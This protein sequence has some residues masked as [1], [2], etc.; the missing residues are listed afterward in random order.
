MSIRLLTASA[1]ALGLVAFAP[2]AMAQ[3]AET[4]QQAIVV[5]DAAMRSNIAMDYVTQLTTRFGARP[6]GSRSEQQAA[7]W[8][9]DYLRANGF[10]NVRIEEFP[11]VGWERGESS[12]AIVGDHAQALVAAALGHS[13]ATPRNGVEAEIVR[14][15]SFEDLQAAPDAAVRGK[16]VYVDL[17]QMRAMQDGSGYGPQ[18]RVRG[19]LGRRLRHAFGRFG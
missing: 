11:L 6:A 7:A 5:R 18:T 8:A 15:A 17:G 1:V 19:A 9:A 16:I 12:A 3:D 2:V 4:V 10:Q 14:F 13:P